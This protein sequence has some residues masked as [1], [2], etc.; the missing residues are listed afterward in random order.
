MLS[1]IS[2]VA[3]VLT[4]IVVGIFAGSIVLSVLLPEMH[5]ELLGI[6]M[7]SFWIGSIMVIVLTGLYTIIGG[8]R[9][10]AYTKAAR[11]MIVILGSILV[12]IF[13]LKALG[14]PSFVLWW[15]REMFNS[16]KP[17]L[18]EGIKVTWAPVMES[19]RMV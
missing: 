3:Y 18:L 8:V 13:G 11:I 15:A 5:L 19:G 2:L 6:S 14:G 17:L 10:V 16:W 12:I 1:V 7:D 4:K 9:A